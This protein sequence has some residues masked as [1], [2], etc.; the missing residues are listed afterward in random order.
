MQTKK[1]VTLTSNLEFTKKSKQKNFNKRIAE[2]VLEYQDTVVCKMK[3]L[4]KK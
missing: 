4:F 2:I 1:K 3:I